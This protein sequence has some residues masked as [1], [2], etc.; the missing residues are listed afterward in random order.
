MKGIARIQSMNLYDWQC[1]FFMVALFL[2]PVHVT[3]KALALSFLGSMGG[4]LSV[5][6][7]IIGVSLYIYQC[8]REKTFFLSKRYIIFVFV[9]ILFHLI[10]IIHGLFVFPK[11]ETISIDQFDKLIKLVAVLSAKG[12][13]VDNMLLGKL[14]LV[15]RLLVKQVP[16]T[17][18]TYGVSLWVASL[19]CRDVKCG[20]HAFL[21]G[22]LSSAFMCALYSIVEFAYLFGA[23]WGTVALAHI[24]PLLYDV[25][26]AHGWWP[27]LLEANRVRSMFAEPAYMAVYLS[28]AI[29]CA[30]YQFIVAEKK[31]FIWFLLLLMLLIM[32]IATNSKTA[33][34]ILFS[35]VLM[36]GIFFFFFRKRITIKSILLPLLSIMIALGVGVGVRNMMIHHYSIDYNVIMNNDNSIHLN[37]T[38][39]GWMP[40]QVENGYGLTAAWYD[41]DWQGIN[42]IKVPINRTIAPGESYMVRLDLGESPNVDI[43]PNAVVE[44]ERHNAYE[45]RRVSNE[46]AAKLVFAMQDGQLVDFDKKNQRNTISMTDLSADSGSNRQRYGMMLVDMKIGL[47][48][49]FMGVGGT[50]LKQGY[51][52]ERIP[53]SLK[54]NKEVKLW[55]KYQSEKGI[56]RS[57][58][59]VI[60]EYPNQF[61]T[62]GV[63]GLFLFLLPSIYALCLLWRSRKKW[64]YMDNMTCLCTSILCIAFFGLM[65]SFI[66]DTATQLYIYWLILGGLLA[67]CEYINHRKYTENN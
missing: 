37:I 41:K 31:K 17:I 63:V 14:W 57:G 65:V 36:A 24:N 11:W 16:E 67:W 15:M 10:S 48:H 28:V 59:P 49:P 34:G 1:I 54:K 18:L 50:D 46:G 32:M 23:Y 58:F 56:L 2:L 61:A 45:K 30:I 39:T 40:W 55:M 26:S 62:Y 25:A 64:S 38:N 29:P 6:P 42:E 27:P 47:E 4:K 3:H 5:Y 12:I 9:L 53:E 33:F 51:I 13:S 66:G 44:L 22:M 20:F 52:V 35:E 43:Y 60:S 7:I 19:F 8:Y 21:Y